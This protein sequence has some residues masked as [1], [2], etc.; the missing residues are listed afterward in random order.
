MKIVK[1]ILE[2]II[3][4]LVVAVFVFLVAITY[5]D[6]SFESN[7]NTIVDII[8]WIGIYIAQARW[9]I[10]KFF[11]KRK[12]KYL[13][14]SA[15]ILIAALA[16]GLIF[17]SI[18]LEEMNYRRYY[19]L[20]PALD[21]LSDFQWFYFR[22]VIYGIFISYFVAS[23]YGILKNIK[24]P[25]KVIFQ[26]VLPIAFFSIVFLGIV[27][28]VVLV[29]REEFA[30][31]P[32]YNYETV[33]E[34]EDI[35]FVEDLDS[36]STLTDIIDIVSPDRPVCVLFWVRSCSGQISNV[37]TLNDIRKETG[38]DQIDF[39]YIV[40]EYEQ[41][42][43]YERWKDIIISRDIGGRHIYLDREKFNKIFIGDLGFQKGLQDS[44]LLLLNSK[45]EI[46]YR[47]HFNLQN[48]NELI[49]LISQ[50]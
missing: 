48:R 44:N 33:S 2:K 25:P 39:V 49:D 16:I 8:L 47:S 22:E 32:E 1:K 30:E 3:E 42:E 5:Q 13:L 24:W 45:R 23:F 46:V 11:E 7:L 15:L 36:V 28:F 43:D 18:H 10:P 34:N 4:I 20:Q 29:A 17:K 6:H 35:H 41:E 27:G 14:F 21:Y 50:L 31:Y 12:P 26:K 40:G 37:I 38:N 9:L 19:S